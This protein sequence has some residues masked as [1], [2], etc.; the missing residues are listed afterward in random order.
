MVS[1]EEFYELLQSEQRE[2]V[3]E[4][5]VILDQD[6]VREIPEYGAPIRVLDEP[7]TNA[8]FNRLQNSRYTVSELAEKIGV[9]DK[10]VRNVINKHRHRQFE[11]LLNE[12]RAVLRAKDVRGP[13]LVYS[14]ESIPYFARVMD[15]TLGCS[16]LGWNDE[17]AEQFDATEWIP[18]GKVTEIDEDYTWVIANYWDLDPDDTFDYIT[19]FERRYVETELGPLPIV[20]EDEKYESVRSRLADAEN[21]YTRRKG[22]NKTTPCE[23]VDMF[24]G[25]HTKG[26]KS[27]MFYQ[28]ISLTLFD[29]LE[30]TRHE[31]PSIRDPLMKQLGVVLE[32]VGPESVEQDEVTTSKKADTT[33]ADT[34]ESSKHQAGTSSGNEEF[35]W[36]ER[37]L[38]IELVALTQELGRLPSETDINDRTR[39][40]HRSYTENFGSLMNAF[41]R[42]GI[43]TQVPD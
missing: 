41:K 14:L 37:E 8:I 34:T 38:L 17:L 26:A 28:S 43:L 23:K 12:Y 1:S 25:K 32:W 22:I 27:I 13:A 15:P 40:S 3:D 29:L 35:D 4:R 31:D 16:L 24:A 9:G 20:D 19:E 21:A 39:F 10:H 6:P 42:A 11:K 33:S 2:L 18:G 36:E 30:Y 5:R 7:L